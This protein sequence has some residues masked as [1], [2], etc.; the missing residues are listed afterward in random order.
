MGLP[1][2]WEGVIQD[3]AST[4]TLAAI[5]TAREAKTQFTSGARGVPSNLSV[6][7]SR[8][9]HSSIDKAVMIAGIGTDNL[10]KIPCDEMG[11]M[12]VT[13]FEA[14]I[15]KDIEMGKL[16]CCVISTIGTTGTMAIDPIEEIGEICR[17]F[18][19]WH[20]V[21][22][23]YAGSALVLP[24]YQW[25]I[26]GIKDANS[27]VFNPHKWMFTNFDCSIYFVKDSDQLIKTF[28]ILPEYLKT[29]RR[30]KVNDYRDW[31]VPLGRRFRALKLWFVIRGMGME[32]I[33][34][35]LREHIELAAYFSDE[36]SKMP[37]FEICHGPVLNFCT[38][39][40]VGP[41]GDLDTNN[42]LNRLLMEALNKRGRLYVSHTVVK[43]R[44]CHPHGHR[45]NL[46]KEETC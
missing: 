32:G 5:V 3:T 45:P 11:R 30:G 12:L 24:E 17:R 40:L 36:I 22:A 35:R 14:Q 8:E 6:Y 39:C 7:C 41:D 16:P 46:C 42:E 38:F 18:E 31:G 21:D 10:V 23:A 27:F 28:H 37:Y 15:K 20:H 4:A 25:M 34:K 1:D 19:I 26:S 43:Q 33:R 2:D 44:F 9:T 13:A 29:W